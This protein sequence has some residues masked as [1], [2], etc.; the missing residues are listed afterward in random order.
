MSELDTSLQSLREDLRSSINRPNLGRVAYRA[1]QRTVRRHMQIG[2]IAAVVLVSVAVPV[3]KSLPTAD[4]TAQ[5]PTDTPVRYQ[6]EF[7]D[8]THGFAL[9][10]DC[11]GSNGP[12][13][14]TL[15]ATTDGGRNWQPRKMPVDGGKHEQAQLGVFDTD[16]LVLQAYSAE[17]GSVPL[18]F[19]SGDTGRTWRE[20]GLTAQ[21]SG[22]AAASLRAQ[23][24]LTDLRPGKE[25]TA[26]GRYWTAGRDQTTGQWSISVSSD[27]GETWAT[28]PVDLP[29]E[30][31]QMGDSWSVV[32][33][34][35]V[36]Y[37]TVRGTLGI[38]PLKLLAVYRSTDE[39]VSWT[40]Q[41]RATQEN[42]LMAVDGSAI[43]TSDGRLLVYSTVD[44]T[45]ES[46]DGSTFA[47]AGRQLPG[48]ATWTRA[49]YL[50]PVK[51]NRYE[52]SQDGRRWRAFEIR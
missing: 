34:G 45:Q 26:G 15:L 41:W 7:A 4:Q 28:T 43:A 24:P 16:N 50:V 13:T 10:S 8:A 40:Q 25:P 32:E 42:V 17:S 36:M 29:G 20:T 33:G 21:S 14:F 18:R 35:G 12:C 46:P 39:G 47:R 23:P 22:D 52:L 38:G 48:P 6:V 31:W 2:A 3:L 51:D 49:G 37:A 1:R 30:P 5:P 11:A 19:T 9:G 44:G 27:A